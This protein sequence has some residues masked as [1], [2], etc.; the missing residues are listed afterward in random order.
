MLKIIN[1]NKEFLKVS[2]GVISLKFIKLGE[3]QGKYEIKSIKNENKEYKLENCYAAINFYSLDS[4]NLMECSS[5]EYCFESKIEEISDKFGEGL[6]IKL[7]AICISQQKI[8]FKLQFKIY[9]EQDFILIKMIDIVDDNQSPLPVH[10]IAPLVIKNSNLWLLGTENPTNLYNISWFK[11]GWQSWS[12]CKIFFGKERDR[13]GPPLKIMKRVL[14]NQDYVIKGRFY[15]E[16]CTVIT[17]LES[18]ISL[19]LGFISFKEQFSR[20]IIDYNN[21]KKVKLLEALGCMDG[22]K[23]N[24]STINTSEELF[25]SFKAKNLGYFGLIDYAK[26]IKAT[27]KEPRIVDI[28]VG[29][30]SWYYYFTKVKFNDIIKNLNFFKQN[31]NNIPIDFIQLDDGYFTKIGDFNIVNNKFSKGLAFLFNRIKESNFKGGIW[32]APFFG[33]KKS[34]LFKNHPDW[35]LKKRGTN[36]YLKALYNWGSFEYALDLTNNEVLNYIKEFFSQLLFA[37]KKTNLNNE[38]Y[39]IDFFKIDFLHASVPIDGDYLDKTLTRAQILYRG[40]KTI[41]DAIT[42]KAFLLGCGAPLG[43]CIGLVDAMRIGTDTAPKW[44][45]LDKFSEKKNF[46]I[47]SLKRGL[48]PVLYRSFMHRYLWIN[49]PDCLMIRRSDTK[50]TQN[51]IR[52]QITVFGISGGQLLISD[53][54]LRLSEEEI[55]DVK[56]CIPPYNS[57]EFDAIPSDILSSKFPSIYM[58]KTNEAIGKRYL[59]A[60]INWEDKIITKSFKILEIILVPPEEESLYLIYDFWNKTFLGFYKKNE[61]IELKNILPH[62]CVYL[63][64]IPCDE[65]LL[66]EPIFLSST[67]HISQGCIEIPEF[68]YRSN[69]NKI[70]IVIDLIGKRNGTIILKLPENKKIL[71]Y[72]SKYNQIDKENNI[73]ELFI[74]F[75]DST[76]IEVE[77][78]DF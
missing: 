42:N 75:E 40:V 9:E 16:Y 78:A 45:I 5:Y 60:I 23:F 39:L 10:S 31:R 19:I 37:F 50:L 55:N 14:D 70:Y 77:L 6:L 11:N 8:S 1:D 15:S 66:K 65:E 58:L 44:Q 25:V 4:K 13:K 69:E 67:L 57:D 47:P 38:K 29:W 21:P 22:V 28:P 26:V 72:K 17:D 63:N 62:S 46:S 51:E 76:S 59:A 12:P 36:K 61:I 3:D 35:F 41:R 68:E 7:S 64:I 2:N 27:M 32:T 52:L 71:K 18:K 33:V 20:I 49:D 53:D 54:M 43:P 30:C 74:N 24:Q 34:E 56:L 48:L 73:W